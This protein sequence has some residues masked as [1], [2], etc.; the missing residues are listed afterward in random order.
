MRIWEQASEIAKNT[1]ED[2]NRY[3]DFLRAASI[4]LVISGHWLIAT[5][6]YNTETGVLTP[7]TVLDII[8]F[9]QWL[10]WAFQVMPIFFIVGGYSNAI[11]LEAAR[12]KNTD[13]ANWLVARLHRLLTPLLLLVLFWAVLAFALNL[14]GV[15]TEIILFASQAALVPT[16]FLAIY[17]M[18]VILAPATHALWRRYGYWS[19]TLYIVLAVIVDVAF[20]VFDWK[21][22]GWSNYFWVW[23]AAHHL[24]FVWRDQ[25]Q[26]SPGALLALAAIAATVFAVLILA[27]PYPVAMAGSPAGDVVSNTLPPKITLIALGLFQFG[28]LLAIE[29]PMRRLLSG[30]SFWTGTVIINTMI[31]T[32]YLWHM[33][34][35]VLLLGVAYLLDGFGMTLEPGSTAWWWTRPVWILALLIPLLPIALMLSPLERVGRPEGEKTPSRWR[36]ITGA[37]LV[38]CGLVIATLVG[39]DG[40]L[41]SLHT[42]AAIALILGGAAVCGLKPT[43][44][45]T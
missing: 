22:L 4:L 28:I 14:I 10:T 34:V 5:G 37:T 12:R 31:M 25:R 17:A 6:F 30:H 15:T 32:I 11:S 45:S 8:P 42:L 35:L 43:V 33:T 18:I 13:Y 1:P 39:F 41:H 7:I 19:L 2:R 36:L 44:R 16:W 26:G 38:G 3:A 40:S 27:G 20:F 23:L 21:W 9:T 29:K 24:G